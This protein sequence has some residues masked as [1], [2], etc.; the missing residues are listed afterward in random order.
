M[1]DGED[2]LIFILG[3]ALLPDEFEDKVFFNRSDLCLDAS[4]EFYEIGEA[5]NELFVVRSVV[6]N[7]GSKILWLINSHGCKIMITN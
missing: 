5:R 2:R 4:N 6:N 7:N 3:L 1:S